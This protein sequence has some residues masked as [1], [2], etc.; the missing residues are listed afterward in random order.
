[1]T[2]NYSMKQ[3]LITFSLCIL[4]VHCRQWMHLLFSTFLTSSLSSVDV[5]I[6]DYKCYNSYNQLSA[7]AFLHS[8]N[9]PSFV[10]LLID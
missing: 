1:M 10:L 6:L 5:P 9:S 2:D 4:D 7:A 3:I 8:Y